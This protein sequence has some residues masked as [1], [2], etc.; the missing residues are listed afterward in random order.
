MTDAPGK[1]GGL[2]PGAGRKAKPTERY[3]AISVKV[4]PDLMAALRN[5]RTQTGETINAMINL[6]IERYLHG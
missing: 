6:A 2:R 5:R 4:R 1:R 3:V